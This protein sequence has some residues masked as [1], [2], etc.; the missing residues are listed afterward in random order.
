MNAREREKRPFLF[1]LSKIMEWTSW[2]KIEESSGRNSKLDRC[3]VYQIRIVNAAREPIPIGRICCIDPDGIVYIGRS[4]PKKIASRM[5]RF[6]RC[7][8][9]SGSKTYHRVKSVLSEFPQFAQHRLEVQAMFLEESDV[10]DAEADLLY[11]YLFKFG[12]LPPFNSK[13]ENKKVEKAL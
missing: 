4:A 8:K 1:C 12:E 13:L 5:G 10:A 3:G 7:K 6:N 2:Y 9:H 11:N